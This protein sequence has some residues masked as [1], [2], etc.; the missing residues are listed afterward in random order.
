MDME[1]LLFNTHDSLEDALDSITKKDAH[2]QSGRAYFEA[3]YGY[4]RLALCELLSEARVD[5]FFVYLCKSALLWRDFL[6]RV[7]KGHP[8]EPL[9]RCASKSFSFIDALTAGQLQVAVELAHLLPAHR[10]SSWEYED[11]FLL[12]RF[13]QA[14]T[15]NLKGGEGLDLRPL[16][17]RWE[18]V[19]EGA[20]DGYLQACQALLARSPKD[21]DSALSEVAVQRAQV[22]REMQSETRPPEL[23]LTEGPI[24][25][26]GLAILRLAELLGMKTLRDYP[27]MPWLARLPLES[28]TPPPSAWLQIT[29]GVPA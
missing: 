17:D 5:R 25:M 14:L 12:H 4:R 1:T 27:T 26:N 11:D 29:Q 8:C 19:L 10:D 24:C 22:F 18:V 28:K 9:Y 15:L 20:R 3:A 23:L 6:G 7:A 21:L 2:E 13:L 16:L